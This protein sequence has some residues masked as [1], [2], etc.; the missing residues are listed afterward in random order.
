MHLLDNYNDG[1]HNRLHID[2]TNT[3][4]TSQPRCRCA[5]GRGNGEN[6]LKTIH[7]YVYAYRNGRM[8]CVACEAHVLQCAAL[9]GR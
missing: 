4:A 1:W 5:R 7:M 6:E 3:C 2:S 8:M 9:F